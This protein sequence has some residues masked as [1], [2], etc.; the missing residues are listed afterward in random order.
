MTRSVPSQLGIALAGSVG[1]SHRTLQG[2]LR[3]GA[4]LVGVL[5]LSPEA[6]TKVG[7]YCRLDDVALNA[8]IPYVEFRNINHPTVVQTVRIWAPDL[9]FVVGLSQLVKSELLR[10]PR[11]GCVG[12]HPTLLPEGRGR[13]PVAWLILDRRPGAATFFLMDE[14]VDSGPI[15]AQEPFLVCERD[16]ASDVVERLERAIDAALDRWLPHLL[17]GEWYPRAQRHVVA[18]YNGRRVPEDGLIN[19]ACTAEEIHALIRASS[20]PH[21]G[22]YT[23]FNGY[24]VI[25]WRAEIELEMPFRGVIGS[26]VCADVQRGCLIQTGNGLL[27]LTEVEFAPRPSPGTAPRIQVGV[28]LGYAPQDEISLLRQRLAEL[29]ERLARLETMNGKSI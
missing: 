9:L 11:L 23:Y 19:W 17:A 22:A 18:S 21:P 10:V 12:F 5:G 13:A 6:A 14:G 20:R 15:L 26:V 1:S 2:L 3:H 27:W 7:G 8:G 4:N 16:Y 25:I 24:K 28:K 29:E